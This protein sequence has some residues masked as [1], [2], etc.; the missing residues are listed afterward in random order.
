VK[1]KAKVQK[2]VASSSESKVPT[3]G[4]DVDKFVSDLLQ[5]ISPLFISEVI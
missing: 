1:A 3:N 2:K 4:A 5:I